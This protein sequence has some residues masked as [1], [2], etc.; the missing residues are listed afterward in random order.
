MLHQPG[1]KFWYHC[2]G[3]R[4]HL[5]VAGPNYIR[6]GDK[7]VTAVTGTENTVVFRKN[8]MMLRRRN[9]R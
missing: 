4:R 9:D 3:R 2:L 1:L 8:D 5:R 7:D 6:I